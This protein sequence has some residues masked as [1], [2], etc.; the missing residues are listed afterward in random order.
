M[1]VSYV[2][3][4]INEA[5]AKRNTDLPL[6]LH[7]GC[8]S[9]YVSKAYRETTK[10]Y[11]LSYRHKGCPYDNTCIESF[12]YYS[13]LYIYQSI[14]IKKHDTYQKISIVLLYIYLNNY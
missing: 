3:D 4:T 11:Q 8:G 14:I 13:A 1:E 12:Q 10:K 7:S 9:Q 2:V 5:E 6:I